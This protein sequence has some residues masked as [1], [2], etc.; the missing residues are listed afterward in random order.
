M[1][2]LWLLLEINKIQ[3]NSLKFRKL[4]YNDLF[5]YFQDNLKCLLFL[6]TLW[7]EAVEF[8]SM[9]IS[10]ASVGC[11]HSG[12]TIIVVETVAIE[13]QHD[14]IRHICCVVVASVWR[15]FKYTFVYDHSL[16][17][18]EQLSSLF[19]FKLCFQSFLFVNN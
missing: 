13:I 10:I 17:S 12:A 9:T 14:G 2:V 11:V 4:I 15:L 5:W 19:T 3:L 6:F 8:I 1:F 7:F 18:C 16:E